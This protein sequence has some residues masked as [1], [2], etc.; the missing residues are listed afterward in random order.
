MMLSGDGMRLMR[1]T[2]FEL[3][4]N[5]KGWWVERITQL[6]GENPWGLYTKGQV[7]LLG[8]VWDK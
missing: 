7:R 6:L 1:A 8:L 5:E 4:I 3:K 2:G